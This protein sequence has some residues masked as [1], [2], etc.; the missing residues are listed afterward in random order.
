MCHTHLTLKLWDTGS[1]GTRPLITTTICWCSHWQCFTFFKS[2]LN[3]WISL[4]QSNDC[5]VTNIASLWMSF[6]YWEN[7]MCFTSH[8]ISQDLFQFFNKDIMYMVLKPVSLCSY[9]DKHI[10]SN[11]FGDYTKTPLDWTIAGPCLE[12]EP[13][14]L[15]FNWGAFQT[16]VFCVNKPHRIFQPSPEPWQSLWCNPV[17][18][19]SFISRPYGSSIRSY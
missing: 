4:T 7:R 14:A 17:S 3:S 13:W 11:S 8:F 5:I 1:T 19:V 16:Y 2:Q 6:L 15:G 10:L 12:C 18:E 9:L